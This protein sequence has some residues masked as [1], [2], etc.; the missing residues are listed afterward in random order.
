VLSNT[1]KYCYGEGSSVNWHGDDGVGVRRGDGGKSSPTLSLFLPVGEPK[2][3]TKIFF[4]FHII[5]MT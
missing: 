5:S 1:E 3:S 2:N 4:L